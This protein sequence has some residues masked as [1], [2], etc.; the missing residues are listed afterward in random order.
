MDHHI[1]HVAL[2]RVL[3]GR[4]FASDETRPFGLRVRTHRPGRARARHLFRLLVGVR[5]CHQATR[6][7]LPASHRI[8]ARLQRRPIQGAL[9]RDLAVRRVR[10]HEDRKSVLGGLHNRLRRGGC[11][12]DGRVRLLKGL[13]QHV[14]VF[15][16]P[17]LPLVRKG[18]LLPRL[19]DDV[20][21]L[22]V[23]FGAV[24][25]VH[26]EGTHLGGI[27][28]TPGAPVQTPAGKCIEQRQLLGQP[29]RMVKPRQ[30]HR[31]PDTQPLRHRRHMR[32]HHRHRGADAV[33]VEV[34]FGQPDRVVPAF[35]HDCNPLERALVDRHQRHSPAPRKELQYANLHRSNP[36]SENDTLSGQHASARA[37][38][39]PAL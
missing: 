1:V 27:E 6:R 31:R 17:V 33:R 19:Q 28:P 35:V 39:F 36:Q 9:L 22:P 16:L 11:Q 3:V 18:S 10:V 14:H 34:V 29:Q 7:Q 26:T 32:P 20:Y 38:P 4:Q 24:I 8:A 30:R 5:D 13:G 15:E 37:E 23:A 21:A 25:R 12:P 2:H